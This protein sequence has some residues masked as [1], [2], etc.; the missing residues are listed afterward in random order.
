MLCFDLKTNSS[1]LLFPVWSMKTYI[2]TCERKQ[3][4]LNIKYTHAMRAKHN[5]IITPALG[6]KGCQA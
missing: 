2:S 1:N 6:L 5:T 3:A 4:K